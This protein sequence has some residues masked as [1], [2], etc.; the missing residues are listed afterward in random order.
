VVVRLPG[1]PDPVV[2]DRALTDVVDRHEVLRTVLPL[3]DGEPYQRVLPTP[4]SLLEVVECGADPV[5]DPVKNTVDGLVAA[6]CGE[7]FDLL[8]DVPIRAR[9]FVHGGGSVLVVLI[10]HV[11]TDGGSL[12]PLLR[13]LSAAFAARSAGRAPGWEPLPVQYADFTLWQRDL[14]GEASDPGSEISEQLDYWRAALTGIPGRIALPAD[15]PHPAE[16][17]G[18]G[19][20]VVGRIGAPAVRELTALARRCRGSLFM[21][22]QA[23]L[24]V[25]LAQASGQDDIPIGSAVAGRSAEE[26]LDDLVGFFVNAV[27]LR[28]DVSGD[29][30]FTDLVVRV[31]ETDL[32]VFAHQD[33]PF[34][35]LVEHLNPERSL[36]CHPFFQVMLTVDGDLRTGIELGDLTGRIEPVDLRAA[37]FDLTV[38]C[39]QTGEGMEIWW[40]YAEDLFEKDTAA[41]LLDL[42]VRVLEA[43]AADPDT[44]VSSLESASAAERAGLADRRQRLAGAVK[45]T[46]R[47]VL[48]GPLT[49]RQ[50]IIAGL[51]AEALGQPFVAGHDNFFRSGG[52]SLLGVRLV[53][54]LRSVLGIEV[55]IRDLFLAPTVVGLD[56]RVGEL[57]DGTRP[58]LVPRSDGGPA[59]LSYAQRRLWFV[60]Q[61]EGAGRSY[62]IPVVVRL[63]HEVDAA[64]L[65][66]AL[67]DVVA[68]HEVLRSVFSVVDDEPFQVVLEDVRPAV[69]VVGVREAGA[70]GAVDALAAQVFDVGAEIPVRVSLVEVMEGGMILVAV[71]HHVAGDGWSVGR[72]LADLGAAYTARAAG[73]APAW[74]PL[75][76]QYGDYA[77][78]QRALLGDPADTDS[79]VAR[80]L[81]YWAG[82]LDGAPALLEF[83]SDRARPATASHRG[84]LMPFEIGADVHRGLA[85]VAAGC[86]AT[87]FMVVQA[88]L[89]TV[90]SRLGAGTDLPIGTVVAGRDDEALHDLVGFFVNTLVLRTDVSGDLTFAELLARVRE[91]D[92]AAYAH[93]DVPFDLLVEHLN[94]ARSA[95]HH[96]LVQVMLS[97][98]TDFG[99]GRSPLSGTE[100]PIDSGVAKFDLTV[101]IRER[102]DA[103]GGPDGLS[104]AV[105]CAADLFEESD[106]ALIARLLTDVLTQVAAEPDRRVA[107]IALSVEDQEPEPGTG[108]DG[109][110]VER[111]EHR[112]RTVPGAIALVTDG[113]SRTYAALNDDADRLAGELRELGVR[114][115][116]LVGLDLER[117]LALA[118]AV[119]GV[120]KCGAAYAP[121]G[122]EVSAVISA[123]GIVRRRPG[124]PAGAPG[125]LDPGDAACV[126][127]TGGRTLLFSHRAVVD[128]VLGGRLVD[129]PQTWL[130]C[131]PASSSAFALEFWGALLVGGTCVMA[132]APHPGLIAEHGLTAVVLPARVFTPMI[133][134]EAL[135]GLSQVTIVGE[136]PSAEDLAR[137]RRRLGHVRVVFARG[138]D[139]GLSVH[140][141][142]YVLDERLRPVPAGVPGE[143][144]VAGPGLADGCPADPAGSAASFVADPFGHHGERMVRTGELVRRAGDGTLRYLGSAAGRPVV[145]GGQ[146]LTAE[147]EAVLARQPSVAQAAVVVRHGEVVAYVVARDG[148]VIDGA[149]L[150]ASVAEVL[151]DHLVPSAVVSLGGLPLTGTG[152]LDHAALPDPAAE[153]AAAR[154][155]S[156]P[157][158]TALVALFSEVLDGRPV[159]VDDNFFRVGGHSLL[160]VRLV[161]RIRAVL[162]LE[163]TLRE[164]FQS[165]TVAALAARLDAGN[166][167]PQEAKPA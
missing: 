94:P 138:L 53:N 49:P 28:T 9:L 145:R 43:A 143:L 14:L 3:A 134:D 137:A 91:S 5:K 76:V 163:T 165:P 151:A 129:G 4:D 110:L 156:G 130:Q 44:H 96:P 77:V 164:V 81:A 64:I 42:F 89:A 153:P 17:T 60:D 162:H 159:S 1:V 75:P 19:G 160:A 147:V 18:R 93:Q 58:V 78:W 114:R 74:E 121:A 144:Y 46:D 116:D 124:A 50:E 107:D 23:A 136:A 45:V 80:Q 118:V 34:D 66:A 131:S 51:F 70:A 126:L 146:V 35:L 135:K 115:G 25:A 113:T 102:R 41:L 157:V 154:P 119:V 65:E 31:R 111:F 20:L 104:G 166:V 141:R 7:G 123:T 97:V 92:L 98:Q 108:Q 133:E 6:F 161:N 40:Q 15:R 26:A 13:D 85:R 84:G 155:P 30:S 16:P 112:V 59:P 71:V 73:T 2:L 21:V 167:V 125:I 12:G 148:A 29:P 95:S 10:H 152:S 105:E 56:G 11:A 61:L 67:A 103:A 120:L 72:L 68:R 8:V 109:T 150:R 117:G 79:P 22:F 48:S 132:D 32:G 24:A 149:A 38:F 142:R 54:R 27:V 63:D 33:L 99:Q 69:N 55:G 86:G 106:P 90:L 37:K 82:A 87:L 47:A 127:R 36:A 122:A 52:H 128:L 139:A 101:A 57:V 39:A 158:E 100:V 83:P 62:N 88:A 140:G